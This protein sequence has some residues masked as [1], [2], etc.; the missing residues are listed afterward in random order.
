MRGD[1]IRSEMRADR[2]RGQEWIQLKRRIMNKRGVDVILV[3]HLQH[4]M[5][6]FE[7]CCMA[8]TGAGTVEKRFSERKRSIM[9]S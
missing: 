5:E 2:K 1:Q 9:G 4:A 6:S 8:I 7:R 3:V